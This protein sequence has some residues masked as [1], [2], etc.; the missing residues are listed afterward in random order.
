MHNIIHVVFRLLV[1][2]LVS[3][4]ADEG[5]TAEDRHGVA[6]RRV[7]GPDVRGH[8]FASGRGQRARQRHAARHCGH[9]QRL[10]IF[11]GRSGRGR[12]PVI[13]PRGRRTRGRRR[14]R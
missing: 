8:G 9:R 2:G 11:G 4:P 5:Q 6:V 12:G 1:P 10:P 13:L 3:K 7:H 14:L